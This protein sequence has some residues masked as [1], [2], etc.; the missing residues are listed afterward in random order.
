MY[1]SD[2]EILDQLCT[3]S[4][5]SAGQLSENRFRENVIR[6]QLE[7]L[8]RIGA[9]RKIGYDTYTITPYGTDLA[10][11]LSPVPVN[12]GL[13]EVQNIA[14]EQFPADSQRLCDF[15]SLDGQ[16]VKAINL[17]L[18][19]ESEQTYGWIRNNRDLTRQRIRNVQDTAIHRLIREFPTNDPLPAQS[20]HW[21]RALV[22]LHLFPD[23]NH[24]TA[25]NTLEYLI[26]Q[27][28]GM[29]TAVV[30]ESIDRTV[31]QSKYIRTFHADVR[32][33]RLWERDELFQLWHRYFTKA[34]TETIE[35]RRPND[36][37][38]SVLDRILEDARE[39]LTELTSTEN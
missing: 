23:A 21:V 2:R 5:L 8:A 37:P 28:L 9:V 31:L 17:E 6:L 3:H 32:C 34:F 10:R 22:G 19:R 24:R 29:A 30:Q 35:G 7:D 33:N 36:P 4:Q 20:A 14:P 12:D 13:F 16:T 18:S 1:R 15:S 39:T 38:T 26:E 25:T 27:E 11:D